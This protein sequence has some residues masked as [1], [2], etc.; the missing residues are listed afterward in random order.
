MIGN[1]RYFM[2]GSGRTDYLD[3]L[4]GSILK[5]ILKASRVKKL[6]EDKVV[7]E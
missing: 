2:R 4:R 3:E 7:Q 5:T 6:L 1:G